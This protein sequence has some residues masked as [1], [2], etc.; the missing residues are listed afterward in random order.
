MPTP[1]YSHL[2]TSTYSY[3]YLLLLLPAP[4]YSYSYLL[5]LLPTPT[6]S[7]LLLPTPACSP[8]YYCLRTHLLVLLT[9]DLRELDTLLA[10]SCWLA[11]S[12]AFYKASKS[13]VRCGELWRTD[14]HVNCTHRTCHT[15]PT[16]PPTIAQHHP[17]PSRVVRDGRA[18]RVGHQRL[19]RAPVG[20]V[21][22]YVGFGR[23]GGWR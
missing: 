5:L 16:A 13:K 6:Y 23:R 12:L 7:C 10:L 20:K 4:T 22:L 21:H 18:G 3:S 1:T 19:S 9:T 11:S 2:P 15:S 17:Q 14:L 8:A